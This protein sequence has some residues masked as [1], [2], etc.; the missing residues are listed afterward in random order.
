MWVRI[1]D[2]REP[3]A[4]VELVGVAGHQVEAPQP[5]EIGVLQDG[6]HQKLA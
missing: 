5:L 4:P 6:A 2:L 1:L 3:E